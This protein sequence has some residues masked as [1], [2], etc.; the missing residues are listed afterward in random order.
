MAKIDKSPRPATVR[1]FSRFGSN[2]YR[3]S[4]DKQAVVDAVEAF[5]QSA[6]PC[7]DQNSHTITTF[8][9]GLKRLA[10]SEVFEGILYD[11][12]Q[13][14]LTAKRTQD[15][16][17]LE[18]AY[19]EGVNKVKGDLWEMFCKLYLDFTQEESGV[20]NIQW[21]QRDCRGIDFYGTNVNGNVVCI[22]AKFVAGDN[23]FGDLGTFAFETLGTPGYVPET[24]TTSLV[25]ITS[26]K[27]IGKYISETYDM[28]DWS[29]MKLICWED[30]CD[31]DGREDFW[32]MV[33]NTFR[34]EMFAW[35]P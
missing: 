3:R 31:V 35:L 10:E 19:T 23:F 9:R 29:R 2:V 28:E 20:S 1:L 14:R 17:A 27:S 32:E 5:I 34:T 8:K 26:A 7:P 22:Q 25:L 33:R 12:K 13:Q 11:N 24:D 18:A 21:A 30:L 15:S 16:E 6:T 4:K